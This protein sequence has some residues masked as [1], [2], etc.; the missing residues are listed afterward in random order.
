MPGR[1]ARADVNVVPVEGDVELP[2][3]DLGAGELA[4]PAPQPLGEGHAA[5]VDADEPDPR[6]VGV[7]LGDLVRDA[8]QGPV[9][10]LTV[11]DSLRCRGLRA[12][13]ALRAGFTLRLLLGL[14]G[15]G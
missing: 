3:R 11:E 9:D 1:L 5:R 6:E 12:Q 15:P 2:Q 10:R 7:A 14:S 4:D 13:S 8:R